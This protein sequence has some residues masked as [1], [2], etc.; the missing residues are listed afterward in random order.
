MA[1]LSSI[2]KDLSWRLTDPMSLVLW[3]G[4]PLIIGGLMSLVAGGDG[5]APRAHLL[6]A[7]QDDSL[8]ST[9]LAGAADSG[10][11][12]EF[13]AIEQVEF[14]EGRRRIDDGDGSAFLV[15]PEG[16]TQAVLDDAPVTLELVT[17]P[18]QSILPKILEEGLE[19]MVDAGF[20]LQRVAGD[21]L[22]QMSEDP[23]T[24]QTFFADA[25]VAALGIAVNQ[26]LRTL[27]RVL[28]PPVITVEDEL[29]AEQQSRV[30]GTGPT[31]NLGL[32]L[33]PGILF[34]SLMFMAQGMSYDVWR[35]KD[36]GTLARLMCSPASASTFVLA[37]MVSSALVMVVVA[38]AGLVLGFVSFG[39]SGAALPGALAW[40]AYSG[41]CMFLLFLAVQMLASSSRGANVL[42]TTL[43]FP[44]MMIGGTFFPFESMPTWMADIGSFT[45][46]GIAVI[47]LKNILSDGAFDTGQLLLATAELGAISCLLF[48]VSTRLLRTRFVAA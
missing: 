4:I 2:K 15:I 5:V 6:V 17:N 30:D 36:Q 28:F 32:I 42:T 48:G 43:L 45:P 22:R 21:L 20:Y 10:G 35:E 34:M 8:L 23:P 24:G 26:R 47:Q 1:L 14:E 31:F 12:L 25:R 19:M 33:L 3:I 11:G 46:N 37:K 38:A 9:A 27:E 44:L 39:L 16:F 13:L 41:A 7:D 40:A 18:S 29:T